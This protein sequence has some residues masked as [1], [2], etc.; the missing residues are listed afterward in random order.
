MRGI[1]FRAWDKRFERYAESENIRLN[2][3]NGDTHGKYSG[4]NVND[5]V[6]EQYTGLKDKN[7]VEIYEGDIIRYI[8]T[9]IESGEG[10]VVFNSCSFVI[11]WHKQNTTK[12]SFEDL[13]YYM[14]C[15]KEL[16]IIGNIHENKE[17][18]K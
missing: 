18:V 6:L 2:I 11:E 16:E 13:L 10:V 1:K 14:Q 9:G 15:S 12:P 5:W 3:S 17:L 4:G 7:G 8:A